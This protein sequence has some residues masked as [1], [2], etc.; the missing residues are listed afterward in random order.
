MN[1]RNLR[2]G[3]DSARQGV[4]YTAILS[5]IAEPPLLQQGRYLLPGKQ[6]SKANLHMS[7]ITAVASQK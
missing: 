5:F 2:G 3:G 1:A 6:Q 4:P 7:C